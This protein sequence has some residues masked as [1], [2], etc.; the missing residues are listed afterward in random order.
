MVTKMNTVKKILKG[1]LLWVTTFTVI[2]FI[3]G[4]NSITDQG[5]LVPWLVVC[6]ILCYLCYKFIS[7]EELEILSGYK[8]LDK[9]IT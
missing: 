8:W 3:S 9:K 5:Y 6:A 2:L 4:V 7:E 1:M